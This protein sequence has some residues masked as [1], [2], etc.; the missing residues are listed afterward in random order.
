M[1]KLRYMKAITLFFVLSLLGTSSIYAFDK[2]PET[3]GDHFSLEGALE[4][5]KESESPEDFEKRLN[6]EEYG[7]H[8]LDLN[9]DGFIDYIQ[10]NDHHDGDVHAIVMQIAVSKKEAQD[11]AVIEIEK[12]GPE[13]AILQIIGD[14]DLYGEQ[15]IVEPYE[16]DAPA[17]RKGGPSF[18]E[19]YR[20][21]VVNVWAWPSVRFIYR[22][23]Y[24]VWASPFRFGYYP[25][26]WRPWRPVPLNVFSP[27]VVVFRPN[28]RV[29]TTHRVVRAHRIYTPVSRKSPT[30]VKK[31]TTY[32][33]GKTSTGR[34]GARKKTTVT[35]NTRSNRVYGSRKSTTTTKTS[36]AKGQ[37]S[38]KKTTTTTT[39]KKGKSSPRTSH[40]KG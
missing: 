25:R 21:V 34:V 14:E 27:K 20:L 28:Y 10:V 23:T 24:S 18:G 2:S 17:H 8:N 40:R 5:F 9:E 19:D 4:L 13:Y 36:G 38:R 1:K 37:G 29:V 3:L 32:A 35:T 30:V 39:T 7:I 31:T 12:K 6:T 15:V 33:V 22:P 16:E 11:V 26:W